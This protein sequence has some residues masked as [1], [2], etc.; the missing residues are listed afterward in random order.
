M[1]EQ[2]AGSFPALLEEGPQ[3][4]NAQG[5]QSSWEEGQNSQRVSKIRFVLL[6]FFKFERFQKEAKF[7]RGVDVGGK[8]IQ[9]MCLCNVKVL[10]MRHI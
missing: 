10:P 8:N 4:S 2:Q 1:L 6:W 7:K 3:P 9:L 5:I